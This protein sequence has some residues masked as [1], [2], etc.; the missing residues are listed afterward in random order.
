MNQ[1]SAKISVS[2]NYPY[3]PPMCL[4]LLKLIQENVMALSCPRC[5]TDVPNEA[6][7]CPYCSLPKPKRG[8][9]SAEEKPKESLPNAPKPPAASKRA[10][11]STR[12][13]VVSSRK[14]K[15]SGAISLKQ[16]TRRPAKEPRRFR[17]SVLSVAALVALLGVGAYIFVVPLVYSNQAEP[18][19]VLAALEK[20]RKTPSNEPELTIDARLSRELETSRRVKNLVAYEGWV[21]RPIKGSKTKVVLAFSY[22]EV[23]DVHHNAEWIADLT[24]GSFIPQ[25]E[26]A[27]A[28][29]S[30]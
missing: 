19:T 14:T 29:S 8:F 12:K 23:G 1:E 20:L 13:T 11:V 3:W 21:V 28:V 5:G 26:L 24:T 16:P 15:E 17:V 25:T 30:R 2:S 7:Y 27:A 6:L 18:K 22:K 10:A 9:A 4:D